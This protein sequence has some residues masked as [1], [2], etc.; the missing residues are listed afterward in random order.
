MISTTSTKRNMD[1]QWL[2]DKR[3]LSQSALEKQTMNEDEKFLIKTW[4]AET[5][6]NL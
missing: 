2:G 1:L 5:D 6:T 4:G 3:H